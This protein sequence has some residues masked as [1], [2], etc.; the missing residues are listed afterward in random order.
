VNLCQL[1]FLSSHNIEIAAIITIEF[2]LPFA[3]VITLLHD[4]HTQ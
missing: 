4:S 2:L 1:S 3:T